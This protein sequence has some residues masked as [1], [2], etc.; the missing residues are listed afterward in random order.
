MKKYIAI[1][2]LLFI[3]SCNFA[4][5]QN[6]RASLNPDSAGTRDIGSQLHPIRKIYASELDAVLFAKNTITIQGGDWLITPNTGTLASGL[7]IGSN[8]CNFGQAMTLNE[9]VEFK[10]A[11]AAEYVKVGSNVTGYIY[12]VTRDLDG[13]GQ[14]MWPKGTPYAD[15]GVTG[16]GSIEAIAGNDVGEPRLSMIVQG[17]TW[18]GQLEV[19][20]IGNLNGF[21][22]Y[23]STAYGMAIGD[24]V[25]Y[26]K[27]DPTNGLRISGDITMTNQSSISI[28]GFNNDA[29]FVTSA[30]AGNKTSYGSTAPGTPATGDFWFDTSGTSYVMKRWSGS[31]WVIVSVYMDGTGLY[32]GNISAG[33]VSAGT[34]YGITL[35]GN[36]I[37]TAASGQR[38]VIDNSNAIYFYGTHA[39]FGSII[40][41]DV[42]HSYTE[43]ALS[44][45]AIS[46]TT[47]TGVA[48]L[49]GNNL[50]TTNDSRLSDARVASDVYTW[51]KA[52]SK[53]TYTYSEVGAQVAGSYAPAAT[54]S[55]LD[56][57]TGTTAGNKKFING[58]LYF[59]NP[60]I[61]AWQL[62]SD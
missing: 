50:V 47:L 3:Q 32:A 31:A 49:N 39:G 9:F 30:S 51:A 8:V 54:G 4:I 11:L 24:G 53:P 61:P 48:T 22:G 23:T 36:T 40:G 59:Y 62:F 27:Y 5:A 16:S 37:Q 18:A 7:E 20:R 58:L 10:A 21:L 57:K 33:Q 55:Y 6:M 1:T 17:L 2:I 38:V 13:S 56:I 14:N 12:N 19:V 25:H 34:L 29:G 52:P 15:R 44:S 60:S 41:N 46:L 42:G 45:F 43:L 26:L 28:S 35:T